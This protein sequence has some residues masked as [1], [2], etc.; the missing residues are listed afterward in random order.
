MS[1]S[2][3]VHERRVISMSMVVV[4]VCSVGLLIVITLFVLGCDK[5]V[6]LQVVSLE[7]TFVILSRNQAFELIPVARLV[8]TE[9]I[10]ETVFPKRESVQI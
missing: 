7:I 3:I 4:H 8:T 9:A 2:E 10:E 6:D 1:V 5:I